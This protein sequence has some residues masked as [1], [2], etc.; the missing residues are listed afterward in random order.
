MKGHNYFIIKRA[1][2]SNIFFDVKENNIDNN[3][4]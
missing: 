4:E 1:D 3:I 2:I